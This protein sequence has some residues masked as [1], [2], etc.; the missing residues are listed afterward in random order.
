M[1]VAGIG[2]DS[3]G[4]GRD[5][6]DFFQKQAGLGKIPF[7]ASGGILMVRALSGEGVIGQD[8]LG[9]R[10]T[11]QNSFGSWWDWESK[12]CPTPL[13]TVETLA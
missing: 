9:S 13:T 10:Q 8:C 4:R 7:G 6:F 5:W 12:S 2:P 1:G 3:F 11:G